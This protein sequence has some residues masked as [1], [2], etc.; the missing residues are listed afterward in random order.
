M[1]LFIVVYNILLLISVADYGKIFM[2][3]KTRL[4]FELIRQ[5]DAAVF[6]KIV[7]NSMDPTSDIKITT[8]TNN[9]LNVMHPVVYR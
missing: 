2:D 7:R 6:K 5:I 4:I 8:F 1:Q 3:K 9:N